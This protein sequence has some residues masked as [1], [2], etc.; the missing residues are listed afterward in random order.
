MDELPPAL[1]PEALAYPDELR[2]EVILAGFAVQAILGVEGPG[3]T[4][5]DLA[6]RW[7]DPARRAEILS[8]ARAVE[9]EPSLL[10]LHPH[11]L[12]LGRNTPGS[13]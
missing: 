10:G 5:P 3:W 2:A 9:S 6:L 12:A 1:P 7:A 8:A 11:I 4:L 13:G